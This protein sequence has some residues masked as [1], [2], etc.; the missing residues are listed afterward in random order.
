MGWRGKKKRRGKWPHEELLAWKKGRELVAR[1]YRVTPSFPQNEKFGLQSQM[2][3]SAVSV[4][5]N[6]AEGAARGSD[7]DFLRF[8]YISRASLSELSTQI[9]I[10]QDL[11]FLDAGEADELHY[12]LDGVSYFLQRL[13]DSKRSNR[14]A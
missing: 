14:R 10:C 12:E 7:R 6:I 8:L 4:L 2:R 1:V 3:R 5:S 13:I 9:F 11:G